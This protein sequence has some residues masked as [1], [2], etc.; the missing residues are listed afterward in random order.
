MV[1]AFL[2]CTCMLIITPTHR[3]T[4]SKC[5]IFHV[6]NLFKEHL[7]VSTK[8]RLIGISAILQVFSHEPKYWTN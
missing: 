5:N 1:A 8:H 2:G 7:L 4:L 6:Q 3:Q